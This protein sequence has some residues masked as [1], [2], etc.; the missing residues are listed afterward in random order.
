MN[1]T[2]DEIARVVA[3][4]KAADSVFETRYG[5]GALLLMNQEDWQAIVGDK[6]LTFG[7]PPWLRLSAFVSRGQAIVIPAPPPVQF[8]PYLYRE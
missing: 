5:K 1:L 8:R 7:R 2:I 4:L 6:P 3:D